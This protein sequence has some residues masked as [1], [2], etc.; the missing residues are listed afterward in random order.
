[1]KI[2]EVI[3]KLEEFGRRHAEIASEEDRVLGPFFQEL[4]RQ[5]DQHVIMELIRRMPHGF[6]RMELRV[7][8]IQRGWVPDA[9]LPKQS[10]H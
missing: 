5:C 7:F 9:V 8:A 2:D 10:T 3:A 1:V 6:Y 4:F